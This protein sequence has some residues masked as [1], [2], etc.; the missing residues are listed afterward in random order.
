M[1]SSAA[2]LSTYQAMTPARN[3]IDVRAY[4]F[5]L[6]DKLLLPILKEF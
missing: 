5:T 3:A 4:D 2:L 6:I 1:S